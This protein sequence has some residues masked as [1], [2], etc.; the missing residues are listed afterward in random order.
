MG[1]KAM[2]KSVA[3]SGRSQMLLSNKDPP[4]V[5]LSLSAVNNRRAKKSCHSERSEEPLYFVFALVVTF[6]L[7]LERTSICSNQ[8]HDRIMTARR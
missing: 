4:S 1:R 6:P 3:V 7:F 5:I 8:Y 2:Q